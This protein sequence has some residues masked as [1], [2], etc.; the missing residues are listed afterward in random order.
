MCGIA[1]WFNGPPDPL[2]LGAMLGAVQHRGPESFGSYE[3]DMA[4][5][6]HARLSIVDVEGGR[7]PLANEDNS[8][9]LICNGEIYNYRELRERLVARGHTFRTGS[10]CEV[11]VHLY[12]EQGEESFAELNGQYAL[13]LWDS[14]RNRLVLCRDRMGICPLFYAFTGNTLYF[15]SEVKALLQVPEIKPEP[16]L[17]SLGAIWTTWA[18][19]PGHT[20]F[21]GVREL[22][23]A[24]YAVVEP[25]DFELKPRRY[26]QLDFTTRDWRFDD[27]LEAFSSLLHDSVRIRL[28]ADVPVGAYLSGGLDSSIISSLARDYAAELHTFSVAFAHADYDESEYQKLVAEHLGT[29][30]HVVFCDRDTLAEALPDVIRHT[31]APQLRAGPISMFLLSESVNRA[32]FKVV[33]T[34]EGSDEFLLGYDLYKETAVRRFMARDP[35]SAVRRQLTRVLYP[36]LPDRDKLQR[37]LDLTFQQ[38][39]DRAQDGFFSHDLRWNK[40]ARL[41]SYFVPEV[42]AQFDAGLVEREIER[43]IPNQFDQWDWA[44]K[45][46]TL[47]VMTFMT[48]YLLAPQGDRVAMA[49]AVEGRFP[50][51]DHRLVEL[52]NSFPISFKLRTLRQDKHI[53]RRFAASRLPGSIAQRPKVPYRAPIQEIMRSRSSSYV[54]DLLSPDAL[55][56]VGLFAPDPAKRLLDKVRG[57]ASFSEMDEMALFGILTTQLWHQMFIAGKTAVRAGAVPSAAGNTHK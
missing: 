18:L 47:E 53:L 3:G 39:L 17:P 7:Q 55:R 52:V 49:H 10:D 38:R 45:A 46:Q 30:H 42:R 35:S 48:P 57:G 31:E 20:A 6:G 21:R 43:Q 28:Q 24:H 29:E 54:D 23:P 15:A 9:W 44:A 19:P 8:I 50:F 4:Q 34:G 37:G 32:G 2:L 12:E 25:G 36:Y 16:D 22:L 11:L 1:G 27:A 41:Q 40:I 14:R 5:L 33:L 13:A 56:E 26:W 51:L